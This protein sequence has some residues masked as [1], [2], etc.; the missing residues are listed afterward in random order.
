MNN[1]DYLGNR[2]NKIISH[3]L[4][5]CDSYSNGS[6]GFILESQLGIE[7][8]SLPIPDFYNIEIKTLHNKRINKF[9]NKVKLFSA[10]PDSHFFVSKYLLEHFGYYNNTNSKKFYLNVYAN[11]FVKSKSNY[12]FKLDINHFEKK[13]FLNIYNENKQL[14]NSDFYWSF[15]YIKDV[16][17]LKM[18]QLAIIY[19]DKYFNSGTVYISYSNYDFYILK[20]FGYFLNAIH[21]G[22]ISISFLIGTKIDINGYS[23]IYDHGTSFNIE[24]KGLH[25]VF[26]FIEKKNT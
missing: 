6:A 5:S 20:S 4:F 11:R 25:D 14:I 17:F 2:L 1:F 23:K 3:G 19:Y 15:D 21:N 13:I 24:I 16:L 7:K 9:N 10:T 26:N 18:S 8:N 12:Y 22:N